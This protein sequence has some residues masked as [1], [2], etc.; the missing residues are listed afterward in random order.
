MNI[1]P[2]PGS[3]SL[4]QKE[5][6]RRIGI[7]S[8][9]RKFPGLTR[10]L[11]EHEDVSHLDASFYIPRDDATL[12][13][14]VEDADLHLDGFARHPRATDDLDHFCGDAVLVG[15]ACLTRVL[16]ESSL[17]DRAQLPRELVEHRLRLARVQDRN[18]SRRLPEADRDAEFLLARDVRVGDAFLLTQEGHVRE[19]LL[20]LHVL[21]HDDELGLAAFDELRDLVRPLADFAALLRAR[22][23]DTS[24]RSSP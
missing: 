16:E 9:D 17:P 24:C 3:I 13:S 2:V 22:S 4:P 8:P 10:G 19:N 14:A 12:V 20:G 23:T 15:H 5:Q 18:R 11:A 1:L 21:R 6:E 7:G